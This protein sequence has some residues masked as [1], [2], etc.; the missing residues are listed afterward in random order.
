MSNNSQPQPDWSKMPPSDEIIWTDVTSANG[1]TFKVGVPKGTPTTSAE[2]NGPAA[3]IDPIELAAIQGKDVLHIL[4]TIQ[5]HKGS[6]LGSV[7]AEVLFPADYMLVSK[8]AMRTDYRTT[9]AKSSTPI[10]VLDLAG[11]KDE[12]DT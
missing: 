8:Q 5:R 10:D 2:V 12:E 3:I 4:E 6:G 9:G 7:V 11:G 1:R